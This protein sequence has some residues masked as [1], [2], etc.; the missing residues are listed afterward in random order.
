MKRFSV[1]WPSVPP[2]KVLLGYFGP[3]RLLPCGCGFWWVPVGPQWTYQWC[4][5]RLAYQ[6][7]SNTSTTPPPFPM[8][9]AY[10]PQSLQRQ[11]I[12]AI[13]L[14]DEIFL[15]TL[16]FAT[17]LQFLQ[18]NLPFPISPAVGCPYFAATVLLPMQ[19]ET[20][21]FFLQRLRTSSAG[22]NQPPSGLF[23]I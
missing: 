2:T 21:E 20:E 5:G 14:G 22:S 9:P 13:L 19:D 12:L 17:F 15:T 6:N 3:L 23:R 1:Q 8:F 11:G 16:S 4:A 7:R 18:R 10:W